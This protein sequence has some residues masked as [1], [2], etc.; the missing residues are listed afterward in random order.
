MYSCGQQDN[1][2]YRGRKPTVWM[3]W[4]AAVLNALWQVF[5]SPPGSETRACIQRGD[6]ETGEIQMFPCRIRLES[7]AETPGSGEKPR[8]PA[9]F[10][11]SNEDTKKEGQCRISWEDSEEQTTRRWTLGS[12][13]GS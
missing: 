13:S 9:E 4:K 7:P 11:G 3:H 10:I 1:S 2:S 5:R 6:S 8:S 12:L